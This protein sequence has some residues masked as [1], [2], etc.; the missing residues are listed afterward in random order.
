MRKPLLLGLAVAAVIIL[1]LLDSSP[2]RTVLPEPVAPSALPA[3]LVPDGTEQVIVVMTERWSDNRAEVAA[4]ELDD[5]RWRK[6]AGAY[7][8][9]IGRNGFSD[10][11]T[12]RVE[13]TPVG[14]FAL[15]TSFGAV[16]NP[17][18]RFPYRAVDDS[19]CWITEA[20]ESF[21]AWVAT[22][23]C[24]ANLKLREAVPGPYELA[25]V[26]NH[27]AARTP[28]AGRTIFM[29]RHEYSPGRA[30]VPTAGDISLRREDLLDLLL[31]LDWEKQPVVVL[32]VESWLRGNEPV[33][34]WID[35]RHG[36]IGTAVIEVQQALDDL[37]IETKVDGN[38]FEETERSVRQFQLDQGL[39]V[40]GIVDTE[41]A[42]RLGVYSG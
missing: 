8:A 31:W 14:S 21:N 11:S 27:N 39:T 32:G 19:D 28:A 9:R 42:R 34:P 37:G 30:P 4:F 20:T 7:S 10:G 24:G 13:V 29:R 22:P 3:G 2:V 6:V 38:F 18:T 41:T 5:R 35:L 17:G 40:S 23:D 1:L 26:T 16:P 25:I 36:A 15:V 33:A 12:E